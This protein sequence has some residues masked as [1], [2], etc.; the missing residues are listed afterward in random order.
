M[1]LCIS[2]IEACY[3][4]K[5]LWQRMCLN[6]ISSRERDSVT[7]TIRQKRSRLQKAFN[8]RLMTHRSL[9]TQFNPLVI[10]GTCGMR[11]PR[12]S[13]SCLFLFF[14][15]FVWYSGLPKIP[16][17][18]GDNGTNTVRSNYVTGAAQQ[19]KNLGNK[20]GVLCVSICNGGVTGKPLW[21]LAAALA[22]RLSRFYCFPHQRRFKNRHLKMYAADAPPVLVCIFTKRERFFLL[23]CCLVVESLPQP[24][25]RMVKPMLT[26]MNGAESTR[27]IYNK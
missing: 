4:K 2:T 8:R 25:H 27:I 18:E 3:T 7:P 15:P 16:H 26:E 12:A 6:V 1:S 11:P 13:I 20:D 24:A 9:S 23:L 22:P 21:L 5:Q 14:I 17:D 10:P 19:V